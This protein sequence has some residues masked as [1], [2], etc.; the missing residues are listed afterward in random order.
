[1][2]VPATKSSAL[3]TMSR[4]RRR[5]LVLVMQ[6]GM[7]A[8]GSPRALGG[9]KRGGPLSRPRGPCQ[10]LHNGV[11]PAGAVRG[12]PAP[13]CRIHTERK[14]TRPHSSRSREPNRSPLAYNPLLSVTLPR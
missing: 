11:H 1:M 6:V 9:P 8:W 2:S 13:A 5:A 12:M 7:A 3:H 4:G 14:G 10:V